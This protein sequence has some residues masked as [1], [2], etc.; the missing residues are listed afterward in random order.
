MLDARKYPRLGRL[1]TRGTDVR[2]MLSNITTA[3]PVLSLLL[4]I[5][6]RSLNTSWLGE[7]SGLRVI[8]LALI[9]RTGRHSTLSVIL[10]E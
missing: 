1:L 8:R 5:L 4:A 10:C 2:V 3:A 6:A 7:N 9:E